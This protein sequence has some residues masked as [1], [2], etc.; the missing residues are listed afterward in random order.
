MGSKGICEMKKGAKMVIGRGEIGREEG[1]KK[2]KWGVRCRENG[3]GTVT[4]VCTSM[5]E[6][7]Q[8][9]GLTGW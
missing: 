8:G 6:G 4:T 5:G 1:G 7:L 9:V 3:G 2:E